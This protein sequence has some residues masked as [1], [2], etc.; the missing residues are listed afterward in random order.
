M[1][2]MIYYLMSYN[3]IK[4]RVLIILMNDRVNAL[5]SDLSGYA[6]G[7]IT[8]N[9]YHHPHTQVY[10]NMERPNINRT[11]E[12]YYSYIPNTTR[13]P[14]DRIAPQS[15]YPPVNQTPPL[16]TTNRTISSRDPIP[17]APRPPISNRRS[18][19]FTSTLP[20]ISPPPILPRYST[21][22]PPPGVLPPRNP[23]Q[24][25]GASPNDI[26]VGSIRPSSIRPI[27]PPRLSAINS[28]NVIPIHIELSDSGGILNG[29]D[30]F[31]DIN[32]LGALATS[33][34]NID[35]LTIEGLTL[36]EIIDR[37]QTNLYQ[38]L[39][40]ESSDEVKCHICNED[41][42]DLDICRKNNIC[43]H[44]FHQSCIDNWYSR[45]KKCPICNQLI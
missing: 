9:Y 16:E 2:E 41:Y 43:G 5:I 45:K 25:R 8:I 30:I 7:S 3:N 13:I 21:I 36:G 26:M 15:F 6:S 20:P 44:F 32:T 12:N 22:P 38:D 14:I 31:S 19:I 11:P 17:P 28:N 10:N 4:K 34:A 40:D 37:T 33:L 29:N 23:R 42:T 18:S 1:N 24:P 39:K 35:A 27:V